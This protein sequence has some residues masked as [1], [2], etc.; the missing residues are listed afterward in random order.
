MVSA[1][2][3]ILGPVPPFFTIRGDGDT[4]ARLNIGGDCTDNN[5]M[6]GTAPTGGR[7]ESTSGK[8]SADSVKR[9]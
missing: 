2:R 7:R 3:S 9:P 6:G 8:L 5:D 1:L 4:Q